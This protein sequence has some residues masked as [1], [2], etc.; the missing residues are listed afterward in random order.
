MLHFTSNAPLN[1]ARNMVAGVGFAEIV[2]G[3]TVIHVVDRYAMG[4]VQAI[5]LSGWAVKPGRPPIARG[6]I[7]F[8][9]AAASIDRGSSS[10][11]AAAFAR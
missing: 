11:P 6:D 8:T 10:A 1:D 4:V 3:S 7:T 5:T 2:D 9:L